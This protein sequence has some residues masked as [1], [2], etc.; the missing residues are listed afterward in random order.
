M[1]GTF[2]KITTT[3]RSVL[4]PGPIGIEK[5]SDPDRVLGSCQG[6][7]FQMYKILLSRCLKFFVE[8]LV[9]AHSIHG[10]ATRTWPAL[11]LWGHGTDQNVVPSTN[12]GGIWLMWRG[13]AGT[14][15]IGGLGRL[16]SVIQ[17]IFS[18]LSANNSMIPSARPL[19]MQIAH[20]TDTLKLLQK[21]LQ[22]TV[23]IIPCSTTSPNLDSFHCNL[24]HL[25]DFH[26][27]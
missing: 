6:L 3:F 10:W 16:H 19:P 11:Q 2:Q 15:F 25:Q 8:T 12:S 14:S 23:L 13:H 7:T 5:G 1:Q 24:Q 21:P 20:K 26:I 22:T 9:E 4:Y 18:N 27:R 17:E